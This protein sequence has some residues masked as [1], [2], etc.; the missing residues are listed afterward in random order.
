MTGDV[1]SRVKRL[2]EPGKQRLGDGVDGE[3]IDAHRGL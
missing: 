2:K 3:G 1:K